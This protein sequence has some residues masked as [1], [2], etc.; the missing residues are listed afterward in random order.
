M[1][2][3]LLHNPNR[4]VDLANLIGLPASVSVRYEWNQ[5]RGKFAYNFYKRG[6]VIDSTIRE[7]W[8][9]SKMERHVRRLGGNDA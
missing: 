7:H 2:Y 5:K 4:A 1:A 8:V 6:A 9:V 3:A